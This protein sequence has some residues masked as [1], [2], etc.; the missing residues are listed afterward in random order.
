MI[1]MVCAAVVLAC[2]PPVLESDP[3]K[4]EYTAFVEEDFVHFMSA[5]KRCQ[6]TC[7]KK[8]LTKF[9]KQDKLTYWAICGGE[10]E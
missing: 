6:E 3:F 1:T 4:I 8:C 10:D 7:P 5:V 9:I 2:A